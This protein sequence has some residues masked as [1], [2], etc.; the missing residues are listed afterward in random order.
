MLK[1]GDEKD[2]KLKFWIKNKGFRLMDYPALGLKDVLCLPAKK[3]VSKYF[4]QSSIAIISFSNCHAHHHKAID[5]SL[6]KISYLASQVY[7]YSCKFLTYLL[8]H[9][10]GPV[11]LFTY[12]TLKK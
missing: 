6:D 7:T 1:D 2:P 12:A 4:L 10:I 8:S 9:I 5:I 3:T 11:T